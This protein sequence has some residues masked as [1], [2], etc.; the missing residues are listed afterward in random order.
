MTNTTTLT[1]VARVDPTRQSRPQA[2]AMPPSVCVTSGRLSSN[3]GS[4]V[5]CAGREPS[6]WLRAA[7][8]P[9]AY[10]GSDSGPTDQLARTSWLVEWAGSAYGGDD[11]MDCLAGGRGVG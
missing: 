5:A 6:L 2:E 3:R 7:G 1:R 8:L 11:V 4:G 9:C 10:C